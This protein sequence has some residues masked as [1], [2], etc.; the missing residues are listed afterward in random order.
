MQAD[1][2][3]EEVI[4][5]GDDCDEVYHGKARLQTDNRKWVIARMNRAKYGDKQDVSLGGIPG[6]EPIQTTTN[7]NLNNLTAADKKA[8]AKL[9]RAALNKGAK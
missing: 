2:Y 3:F 1:H 7:V 6:S 5:L 4:E 9:A 8:A